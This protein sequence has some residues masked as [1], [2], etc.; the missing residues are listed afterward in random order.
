MDEK[1]VRQVRQVV[2][3]PGQ[4]IGIL[5]QICIYMLGAGP[6]TDLGK[7]KTNEKW[8]NHRTGAQK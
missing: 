2:F 8:P 5:E 7:E 6:K 3:D 4:P 1:Q